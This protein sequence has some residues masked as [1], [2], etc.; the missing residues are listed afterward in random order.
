[1]ISARKR[2]GDGRG[3]G[4]RPRRSPGPGGMSWASCRVSLA[5][6]VKAPDSGATPGILREISEFREDTLHLV[7][8]PIRAVAGGLRRLDQLFPGESRGDRAAVARCVHQEPALVSGFRRHNA[9]SP[10]LWTPPGAAPRTPAPSRGCA[11]VRRSGC[12]AVPSVMSGPPVHQADDPGRIHPRLGLNLKTTDGPPGR[13][14]R[15]RAG[16]PG[17][18]S[19]RSRPGCAT[20]SAAAGRSGRAPRRRRPRAPARCAP[21]PPAGRRTSRWFMSGM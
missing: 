6:Y 10:E 18:G 14:P 19:G 13:W 11:A 4:E 7:E 2:Y 9:A 1:M 15:R 8:Q 12:R 17:S 5:S 20:D 3:Q 21:P 16:R